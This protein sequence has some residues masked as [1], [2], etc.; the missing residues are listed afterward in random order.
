MG[1]VDLVSTGGIIVIWD[2]RVVELVDQYVGEFLVL[3]F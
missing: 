3:S 2:G 1:W